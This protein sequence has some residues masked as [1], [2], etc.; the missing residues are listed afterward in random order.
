MNIEND[1]NNNNK[2]EN[3]NK[4]T[5]QSKEINNNNNNNMEIDST[6]NSNV[7]FLNNSPKTPTTNFTGASLSFH[8]QSQQ[9]RPQTPPKIETTDIKIKKEDTVPA[10]PD[11]NIMSEDENSL[12]SLLEDSENESQENGSDHTPKK[13][14]RPPT[15]KKSKKAKSPKKKDSDK[16]KSNTPTPASNPSIDISTCTTPDEF[17]KTLYV[18]LIQEALEKNGGSGSGTEIIDLITSKNENLVPHKK[19]MAYAVNAILS[20]KKYKKLFIKNSSQQPTI[21]ILNK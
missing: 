21:W 10:T 7:A 16:S 17:T 11:K 6:N 19:K 2:I 14:G 15:N 4:I 8:Q 13:K 9:Q 20:S 5:I 1:N 18:D 3:N 12:D